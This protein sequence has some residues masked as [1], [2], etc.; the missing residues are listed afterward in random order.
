MELED[1]NFDIWMSALS[2]SDSITDDLQ[3]GR[4]NKADL[5]NYLNTVEELFGTD[6]DPVEDLKAFVLLQLCRSV[7]RSLDSL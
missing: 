1:T 5:L 7:R 4:L 3:K 6:I 2:I